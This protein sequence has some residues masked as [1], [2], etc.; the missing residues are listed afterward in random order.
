MNETTFRILAAIVLFTGVGI[1]IYFRRKADRDSGERLS[2][3][4]DG[5]PM[6]IV[7]RV[8][9]MALWLSPIVYLLNPLWMAWSKIGSPE[10]TRWFG[11]G[12]GL[13]SVGLIYWLFNSIGSGITPVSST[14]KEHKLVTHGIYRWVRH[15]LYTVGSSLYISFGLMADNWFIILMAVLA[16]I[17]M[18]VRTPKE[19]ANLIEKFGDEYREY[20][21]RT[22]RFLPKLS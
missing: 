22:G 20:M 4:A 12:L 9:G 2:R 6:M 19:E 10:W 13:V 7:I 21:K 3:S 15:P 5:T 18:A 16:F 11:F 17:V 1:S 8:F 14:R